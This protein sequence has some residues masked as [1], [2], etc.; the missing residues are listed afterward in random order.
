[1][2]D[3]RYCPRCRSELATEVRGGRPRR[4]CK[5]EG[6]RFVH[7]DNPVPVVATIVERDDGVVLVRSR[8]SPPTWF[9]LVAG[10]LEPGERPE[11]GAAR[12]V[13]EEIG[14]KGTAPEL[15]G[16]DPFAL[17]NQILFS[18]YMRVPADEIR[19]SAEEL[20]DY[21]IVPVEKLVPWNR[22]TGLALSRWLAARGFHPQPV[23]FGKHVQA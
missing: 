3:F 5:T 7:W 2:N 16:I 23:D 13:E 1:M 21:R 12:E 19:L 10:F 17:R 8:G 18:Y 4:V 20:E 14:L 11:D 6:C 9:G 22:G 15:I